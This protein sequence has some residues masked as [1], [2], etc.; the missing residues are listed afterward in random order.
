MNQAQIPDERSAIRKLSKILEEQN[1]EPNNF[2][3]DPKSGM[4]YFYYIEQLNNQ[5]EDEFQRINNNIPGADPMFIPEFSP[6]N[7]QASSAGIFFNS[8]PDD[9]DINENEKKSMNFETSNNFDFESKDALDF[10]KK[11]FDCFKKMCL[12]LQRTIINKSKSN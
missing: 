12:I 11:K 8:V 1:L 6:K 4:K 3:N 7:L 5:I 10:V 2:D 9:W